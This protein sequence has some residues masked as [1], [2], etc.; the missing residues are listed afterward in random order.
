MHGLHETHEAGGI[1]SSALVSQTQH[2]ISGA[3]AFAL[4]G[5][6]TSVVLI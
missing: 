3:A 2:F 5:L 4:L 1:I 6:F